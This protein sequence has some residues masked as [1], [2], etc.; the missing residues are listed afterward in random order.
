L[1]VKECTSSLF[2]SRVRFGIM[3]V[4][5]LMVTSSPT[6]ILLNPQDVV[7]NQHVTDTSSSHA[8]LPKAQDPSPSMS[9]LSTPTIQAPLQIPRTLQ[10]NDLVNSFAFYEVTF[11]TATTGA[12]D[13]IRM[14][15][16]AG[17]GVGAAGIIERIGIGGGTLL[18][19]GSSITYDVTNPVSIPAGTFIR[20]E[21]FGMKNPSGSSTTFTADITTRDSAGNLIDG[22]SQTNVFTIKQIVSSDIANEAIT[23]EKIAG[24]ISADKIDFSSGPIS[25]GVDSQ[26]AVAVDNPIN[27]TTSV[28]KVAGIVAGTTIFPSGV[29]AILDGVNGQQ[30]ILFGISETNPIQIND[31]ANVILPTTGSDSITLCCQA[32]FEFIFDAEADAW[33][34]GPQGPTGPSQELSTIMRSGEAVQVNTGQTIPVTASC[35]SGEVA[36]GGGLLLGDFANTVNPTYQEVGIPSGSPTSWTVT[37]ANPGPNPISVTPHVIC[38]QLVP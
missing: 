19:S 4:I 33:R 37:F 32:A 3:M 14:D 5:M 12:I 30:L 28:I 36:T 26:T 10:S 23:N 21:M 27:P 25:F 7:A 22:P 6:V 31:G 17:T 24:P 8:T 2:P 34:L 20:L 18:K 38:A 1:K 13:K 16:P 29:D 11:I 9:S 15:F 35:A